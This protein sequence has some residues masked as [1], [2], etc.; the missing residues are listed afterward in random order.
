MGLK[1]EAGCGIQR[2]LEAEC[3]IKSSSRDRDTQF[4][5]VVMQ[6]GIEDHKNH[7]MTEKT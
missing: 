1:I 5:T 7:L 4:F 3:G 6:G 2:T